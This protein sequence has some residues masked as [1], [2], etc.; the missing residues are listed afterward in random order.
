MEINVMRKGRDELKS[1]MN[2]IAGLILNDP[3]EIAQRLLIPPIFEKLPN[4]VG[5]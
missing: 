5:F 4:I 1:A 2:L 3:L